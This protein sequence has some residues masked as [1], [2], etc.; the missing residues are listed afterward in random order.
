MLCSALDEPAD[1]D[2]GTSF[3]PDEPEDLEDLHVDIELAAVNDLQGNLLDSDDSTLE[4]QS[5]SYSSAQ[6]K[7]HPHTVKVMK[8][9]RSSLE[10]K[11]RLS[12]RLTMTT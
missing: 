7:W 4:A 2:F 3:A 12:P 6:H 1:Y 8:V 10:D 5:G 11:V 9:L